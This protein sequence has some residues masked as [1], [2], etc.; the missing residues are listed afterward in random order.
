MSRVSEGFP[1]RLHHLAAASGSGE[2]R[3]PILLGSL[4]VRV[5]CHQER[6][7][8]RIKDTQDHGQEQFIAETKEAGRKRV[9]NH[10]RSVPSW[11]I[12]WTKKERAS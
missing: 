6:A 4:P 9:R 7:K 5:R 1:R 8:R 11:R 12:K 10:A 3:L 2:G